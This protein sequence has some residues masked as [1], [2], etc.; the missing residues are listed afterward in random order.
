MKSVTQ[1]IC[2]MTRRLFLHVLGE[3]KASGPLLPEYF[4]YL[5]PVRTAGMSL[6]PGKLAGVK[7]MELPD[8]GLATLLQGASFRTC[9]IG[10]H[11]ATIW[12]RHR[13]ASFERL[14]G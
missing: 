1:P 11:R 5:Q 13:K 3:I 10:N 4:R 8:L 12:S 7:M 6:M 9:E 14:R 2:G